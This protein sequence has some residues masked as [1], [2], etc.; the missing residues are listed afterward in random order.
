MTLIHTQESYF[1]KISVAKALAK[2]KHYSLIFS[3][4]TDSI[5]STVLCRISTVMIVFRFL[6]GVGTGSVFPA[7]IVMLM[8]MTQKRYR[9]VVESG[10][11]ITASVAIMMASGLAVLLR[12]WTLLTLVINCLGIPLLVAMFFF[13]ESIRWLVQTGKISKANAVLAK[14]QPR[15][16]EKEKFIEISKSVEKANE[17]EPVP[18]LGL[19]RTAMLRRFSFA[20]AFTAT[21]TGLV[22][23]GYTFNVDTLTGNVYVNVLLLGFTNALA[24]ATVLILDRF[25][26]GLKRKLV[27]SFCMICLLIFTV[28]IILLKTVIDSDIALNIVSFCAC[29]VCLP[30]WTVTMLFCNEH[31]P[32]KLRNQANGFAHVFTNVGGIASPFILYAA[33]GWGPLPYVI[34]ASF[35]ALNLI[36]V[37]KFFVETKGKRLPEDSDFV[38]KE[39]EQRWINGES[40]FI[41]NK[42]LAVEKF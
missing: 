20:I 37:N 10:V 4:R 23:F 17:A 9:F 19:F 6:I 29:S 33:K 36:I 13:P 34:F 27:H 12:K 25:T 30:L 41:E 18:I 16:A 21:V 38:S 26:G 32:T 1:I 42:A 8:E 31:F 35:A 28:V 7:G 3:V 39:A 14:I 11:D 22:N 40:N 2:P 15:I 24:P 5:I